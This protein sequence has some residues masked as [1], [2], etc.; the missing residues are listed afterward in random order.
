MERIFYRE[1][2]SCFHNYWTFIIILFINVKIYIR[3]GSTIQ[4]GSD[5]DFLV[6]LPLM[7]K[8]PARQA[9]FSL[10]AYVRIFN[11]ISLGWTPIRRPK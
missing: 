4:W 5:E 6:S 7:D 10:I 2:T 11:H 1:N 3:V 9:L 8:P